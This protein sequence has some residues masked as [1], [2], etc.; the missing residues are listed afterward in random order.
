[1]LKR[2]CTDVRRQLSAFHDEELPVEER[3]AIAAHL[4]DCPGCAVEA[5]DFRVIAGALR[6]AAAAVHADWGSEV[7]G[8]ASEVLGRVRAERDES[9][10]NRIGRLLDDP[11]RLWAT[12]GAVLASTTCALVIVGLLAG[13]AREHARS[14]AAAVQQ[15]V[16]ATRV[17]A[18]G[19]VVLPRANSDAVMPAAVVSQQED[20]DAAS[21][22]VAVVTRDGNLADVQL[23]EAEHPVRAPGARESRL[24]ADLLAAVATARFE[25]ARIAGAPV[26]VNMVWLL[27]HTTVRAKLLDDKPPPGSGWPRGDIASRPRARARTQRLSRSMPGPASGWLG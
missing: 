17:R 23:L 11:G 1:M 4:Q 8:L 24:R 14:L 27:A 22:F 26:A 9:L 20:E 21:A 18:H 15:L 2:D 7:S 16:N 25:P 6:G 13:M 10:G 19:P 12:G 5:E 3:I